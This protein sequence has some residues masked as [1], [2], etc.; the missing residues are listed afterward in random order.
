MYRYVTGVEH[1]LSSSVT[2]CEHLDWQCQVEPG[3]SVPYTM[4]AVQQAFPE[5][6][7][8]PTLPALL[9]AMPPNLANQ[10]QPG[11]SFF[12][13]SVYTKKKMRS[14]NA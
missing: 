12:A 13:V 1:G 4:P 9:L 11:K 8:L 14:L 5:L 6:Q 10:Q 2:E 7:P 3:C